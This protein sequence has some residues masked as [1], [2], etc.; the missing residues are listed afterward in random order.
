MPDDQYS[1]FLLA[2]KKVVTLLKKWLQVERIWIIVE[3]MQVD[4]A[5]IKLYPFRGG[6]SFQWGYTGSEMAKLEDLQN[7]AE[8]IKNA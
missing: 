5:H 6:K 2:V 3:G 7:L 1:R 8:K 4:H